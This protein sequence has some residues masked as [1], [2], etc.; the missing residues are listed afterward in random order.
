MLAPAITS[1]V[2][3]GSPEK[4]KMKSTASLAIARSP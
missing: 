3:H 4:N 1:S 2:M